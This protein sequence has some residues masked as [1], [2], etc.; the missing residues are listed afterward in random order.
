MTSDDHSTESAT[1]EP[2]AQRAEPFEI[3][4][5]GLLN[6]T[7]MYAGISCS[8][9]ML[10]STTTLIGAFASSL[11]SVLLG[12]ITFSESNI[13]L[14]FARFAVSLVLFLLF[15]YLG[16]V[17]LNIARTRNPTIMFDGKC[18]WLIVGKEKYIVTY[19]EW[20][21]LSPEDMQKHGYIYLE[22]KKEVPLSV[23]YSH[24]LTLVG[25]A[26]KGVVCQL[27]GF[28]VSRKEFIQKISSALVCLRK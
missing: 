23:V 13:L 18:L 16:A 4:A 2:N 28:D 15:G 21:E 12:E 25:Y 17:A 6:K 3:H 24:K 5:G 22:I 14:I 9:L 8:L 7:A 11:F 19:T 20:L 1:G 26:R 10:F 27:I